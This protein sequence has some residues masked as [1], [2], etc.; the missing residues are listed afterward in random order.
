M[1]K[2]KAGKVKNVNWEYDE[3]ADILEISF[4]KP[5]PALS[6][7]LGSGIIVRYLEGTNEVVGLTV[8]GLE[9]VLKSKTGTST[10]APC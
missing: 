7:D 3:E 9:N 5:Q 4:G 1:E 8:I 10:P 2:M 6:R